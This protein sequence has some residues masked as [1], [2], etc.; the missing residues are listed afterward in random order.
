M[1]DNNIVPQCVIIEPFTSLNKLSTM[2]YNIIVITSLVVQH[3]ILC[4]R[5]FTSMQVDLAIQQIND[6]VIVLRCVRIII[7]TSILIMLI[8]ATSFTC[9]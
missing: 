4:Y 9:I 5:D 3:T 1:Y 6:C 8:I 7:V 2:S